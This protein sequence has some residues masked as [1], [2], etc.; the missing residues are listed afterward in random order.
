MEWILKLSP[1]DITIWALALVMIACSGEENEASL[2]TLIFA[3]R[4]QELSSLLKIAARRGKRMKL[5]AQNYSSA[6]YYYLCIKHRISSYRRH[7]FSH[8]RAFVWIVS[9]YFFYF[10]LTWYISSYVCINQ[11]PRCVLCL[12]SMTN[13]SHA[14]IC[15]CCSC[16]VLL[17]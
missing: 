10:Y 3:Y 7:I 1:K 11:V 8:Q 14:P 15:C 17:R 2:V 13:F 12:V 5:L 6:A 4:T 9:S 16:C